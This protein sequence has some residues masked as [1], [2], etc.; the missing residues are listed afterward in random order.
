ML[1]KTNFFINNKYNPQ[2][3]MNLQFSK[4]FK[5]SEPNSIKTIRDIIAGFMKNIKY[6]VCKVYII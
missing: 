6:L 3:S 4:V 5:T 2:R 1:T